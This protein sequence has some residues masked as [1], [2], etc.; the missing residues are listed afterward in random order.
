LLAIAG[1]GEAELRAGPA[2]LQSAEFIVEGQLFP[3]LEY[4]FRHA[5]T[6]DVAY[7]SLLQERRCTLHGQVVAAMERLYGHRLT[8]HA[9]ALGHHA[10]LGQRW[11]EA[12]AYLRLAAD[13]ARRRSA[14]RQAITYLE[15]ALA[16][17][18]HLPESRARDEQAVD[19]RID[20]RQSFYLLGDTARNTVVVAEARNTW[21]R[22]SA[23]R[24]GSRG[25]PS[26][27]VRTSG[28]SET[29]PTLAGVTGAR[30]RSPRRAT[31]WD[32]A[33]A[34]PTTSASAPT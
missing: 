26:I 19:V 12:V 30:G 18:P 2:R 23:T 8:E 9:E 14:H 20:L 15:Q 27:S 16:A 10:I 4:A 28:S 5:L 33:P 24:G 1:L 32:F 21:P 34:R 17:L 3:D 6:H 29:S 13:K 25:S 11:K 31:T 22:R 7:A